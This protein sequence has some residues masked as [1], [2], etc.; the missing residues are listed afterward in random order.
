MAEDIRSERNHFPRTIIYCRKCDD[1]YLYFE[2]Y[3]GECFTEPPNAS[4]KIPGHR[5]VDMFMNCTEEYVKEEIIKTLLKNQI[6]ESLLPQW[7]LIWELTVMM[8]VK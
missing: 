8:Y 4:S 2:E 5:L 3:L 6:Y 1:I 7:P